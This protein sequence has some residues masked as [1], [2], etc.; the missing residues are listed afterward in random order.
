[1]SYNVSILEFS[2]R[3]WQPGEGA[4]SR[5]ET[6]ALGSLDDVGRTVNVERDQPVGADAPIVAFL[7]VPDDN[8]IV[9]LGIVG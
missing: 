9:R 2:N 7:H 5:N 6:P 1:M 8:E 4:V 3:D